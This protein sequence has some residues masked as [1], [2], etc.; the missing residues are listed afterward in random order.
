[1][2]N[3]IQGRGRMARSRRTTVGFTADG[4]PV[5]LYVLKHDGIEV[6]IMN[7]GARIVSIRTADRDGR[8][9]N[10]VLSY[11][12]LDGYLADISSYHG[13][14]VGRFA[15]R[16]AAGRFSLNGRTF[17][18]VANNNGNTLH[19]GRDGFDRRV[20]SAR[21]FASGT[22]LILKSEDG[23]QGFPGNLDVRV[24]YTVLPRAL[25]ID[26]FATTDQTTVVNLTNHAYFNLSGRPGTSI[27]DHE[28]TIA[29]DHYTPID[30]HLIPA[31]TLCA[32]DGT[33][34]DFRSTAVI[35]S[36]INSDDPQLELARG[37][38]H[39]FVLNGAPG[40]LRTVAQ[41]RHPDT[42]RTM[43]AS[44]T[45]P[46]LQLYSGNFLDATPYGATGEGHGKRTGLCLETQH[47]PDSPNHPNFPSTELRPG[48]IGHSI[49]IF[50]FSVDTP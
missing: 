48:R 33:P 41:L 17:Q 47:Y 1:M 5:S 30:S 42:G 7:Y 23:D 4:A 37:Y 27:L 10:V 20:W 24:R 9:A 16:I 31:G 26:Y 28:L 36:H 14:V 6:A 49:T 22:E 46:G 8:M 25:R 40:E 39:N 2:T 3:A 21:P 19:G 38:D 13:A 12:G 29:A 11:S 43:Y 50:E 34:F 15:N 18:T 45:E 35:G 32:V 44:T